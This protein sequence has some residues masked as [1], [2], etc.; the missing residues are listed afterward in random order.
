MLDMYILSVA[1]EQEVKLAPRSADTLWR[2]W[3][4]ADETGVVGPHLR[5]ALRCAIFEDP[6]Y[7]ERAFRLERIIERME[8][9]RAAHA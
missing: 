2:E 9:R 6:F 5:S 1:M 8:V 3:R 4:T 7:R